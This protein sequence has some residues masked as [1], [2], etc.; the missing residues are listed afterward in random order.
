[1]KRNYLAW[2]IDIDALCTPANFIKAGVLAPSGHNSQPW[3]FR[4]LDENTISVSLEVLRQL[5]ASDKNDRQAIISIGCM[6][7]NIEILADYHGYTC[8]I[9]SGREGTL[10]TLHFSKQEHVHLGEASHL[11]NFITKRVTNR[12]PHESRS[13]DQGV[14]ESI[15][16]LA[17]DKLRIDI[18]T[19]YQVIQKLGKV[20]IDAGVTALDDPEFRRELSSYL[21][22][23][24][25]NSYIGMPGFGFGFPAPLALLS[26]TLVRFFNM[27]KPA[28]KQNTALFKKTTAILML[29][30]S[31]DTV[32]DWLLVGRVYER[33][34]LLA[35]QAGIATAPWAAT[36]QIGEHYRDLQKILSITERPQFFCRLGFPIKETH[37]SPRLE[38]DK[39]TLLL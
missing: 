12:S 37:H 13:I 11:A 7:A 17:S 10:A 31:A 8:Y 23:N 9:E 16:S 4:I 36:V 24:S 28:K 34:A 18:V 35:T 29:S 25:T 33:A 22:I 39:V 14:L 32:A 15:R 30:T 20:A 21:K 6:M 27:E 1:M 3:S 2:N 26:P 5:P 19:D 38:A